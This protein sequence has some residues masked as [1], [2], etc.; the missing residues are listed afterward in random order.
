MLMWIEDL[1]FNTF[2][3]T[4][5]GIVLFIIFYYFSKPSKKS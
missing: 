4:T 2:F 3:I 5:A 1:I